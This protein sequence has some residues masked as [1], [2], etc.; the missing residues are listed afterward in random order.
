MERLAYDLFVLRTYV[1]K[2]IRRY[3]A[4]LGEI[5]DGDAIWRSNSTLQLKIDEKAGIK[6]TF[7]G[8]IYTL[9]R[10]PRPL[11]LRLDNLLA[12]AGAQYD[13][14]I[15]TVEHVLPQNPAGNS[16][17]QREFSERERD[18]WTHRL[19]NLVL[20]SRRKHTS[21]SNW[22]FERKKREYFQRE[23]VVPFAL[24]TRVINEAEWTPSVLQRR[25]SDLVSRLKAEWRL[26]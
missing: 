8:P 17:W 25:Q 22:D 21:A 13:H 20:L 15:I 7:D 19:G 2:R 6:N 12:D 1:T 23:S 9:P 16:Q 14:D 18:L 4:V 26:D 24:T 5:E 3:A 10:V 11:L